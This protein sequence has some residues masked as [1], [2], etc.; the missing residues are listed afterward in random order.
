MYT[1]LKLEGTGNINENK[2]SFIYAW[3]F[4][5]VK[6]NVMT[7]SNRKKIDKCS[8]EENGHWE[9]QKSGFTKDAERTCFHLSFRQVQM[10]YAELLQGSRISWTQD[11]DVLGIPKAWWLSVGAGVLRALQSYLESTG[12][13]VGRQGGSE[14]ANPH[15]VCPQHHPKERMVWVKMGTMQLTWVWYFA[16]RDLQNFWHRESIKMK[17]EQ[18]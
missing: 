16:N 1:P 5:R 11:C 8:C 2:N 18:Y 4:H 9:I 15:L 10:V 6:Y 3:I 14:T 17:K 12:C 13:G 7:F